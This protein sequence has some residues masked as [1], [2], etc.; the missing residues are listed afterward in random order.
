MVSQ[1]GGDKV[2]RETMAK[3][4]DDWSELNISSE[5]NDYI[6]TIYELLAGRTLECKGKSGP[7]SENKVPSFKFSAR[8]NL[9]WKRA[10]GLRLWYG[11]LQ[12]DD[13]A[14]AILQFTEDLDD[15]GE[16]A[17]PLPWFILENE[18]MDWDDPNPETREDALWGLLKFYADRYCDDGESEDIIDTLGNLFPPENTSGNPQ[19]PRLSFQLI[20]LLRGKGLGAS[21]AHDSVTTSISTTSI[22]DELAMK[23]AAALEPQIATKPEVLVVICWVLLHITDTATRT[24]LLKT[25]LDR[26]AKLL[27][28]NDNLSAALSPSPSAAPGSNGSLHIP[29]AWLC[30]AKATY[31]RSVA[32][33][34]LAE[35][36][37]LLEGGEV[38]AAHDV[39]CRVIGP[40]AVVEGEWEAARVVLEALADTME[41]DGGGGVDWERGAGLFADYVELLDLTAAAGPKLTPDAKA[42]LK[43]LVRK[44]SG[45]LEALAAEGVADRG[46][47]EKIAFKIMAAKVLE[48]GNREGVS[49]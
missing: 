34:P 26:H 12:L 41:Q 37:W 13:V 15:N 44:L 32:H 14:S 42:L 24:S 9:D 27:V 21:D 22:A 33:D 45:S 43:R 19:D 18:D 20:N 35:A 29:F 40:A 5:M 48:I 38:R 17:M 49:T 4:L 47:M 10:F 31:A 28:D 46:P 11:T 23:L 6:R 39:L 7:G 1:I 8:F 30:A 16:P 2:F 25:Q 36:R 3:Q